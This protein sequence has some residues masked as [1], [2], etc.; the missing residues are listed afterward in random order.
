MIN[1]AI[2]HTPTMPELYITK[3]KILKHLGK[4]NE[5]SDSAEEGRKLDLYDRYLNIRSV[6]Y[7]LRAGKREQALSTMALFLK[8]EDGDFKTQVDELQNNWFELLEA[9]Y[10]IHSFTNLLKL[11]YNP[12]SLPN[13]F[14]T[15]STIAF[16]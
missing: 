10:A 1:K 9:E 8:E 13:D 7:L 4:I 15:L 11:Y 14:I 3:A 12:H 16:I 6:G 5:A 2:E